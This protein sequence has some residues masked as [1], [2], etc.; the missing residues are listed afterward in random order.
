MKRINKELLEQLN[1]NHRSGDTTVIE[2]LPKT[3]KDITLKERSIQMA[4]PNL[5]EDSLLDELTQKSRTED[6]K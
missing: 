3:M 6:A 1:M 2:T 4:R 5:F